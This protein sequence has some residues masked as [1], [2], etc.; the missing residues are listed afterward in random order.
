MDTRKTI[1][2]TCNNNIIY[3]LSQQKALIS[4][5]FGWYVFI[6]IALCADKI[7]FWF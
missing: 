4:K 7:S 1:I 2:E 6:I 3:Y 5:L